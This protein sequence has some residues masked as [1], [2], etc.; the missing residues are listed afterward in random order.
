MAVSTPLHE[1]PSAPSAFDESA[2]REPVEALFREAKRRVR[3]RR[4]IVGAVMTGPWRV[5]T[6]FPDRNPLTLPQ[7]AGLYLIDADPAALTATPSTL[8][9]I[10][11]G[12][13]IAA[14]WSPDGDGIAAIDFSDSGRPLVAMRADGSES[15]VLVRLWPSDLFSGLAWHPG[16]DEQRMTGDGCRGIRHP[17]P[18]D[19]GDH[20]GR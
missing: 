15:R 18:T 4:L 14:T 1:S 8:E 7:P 20:D 12:H 13:F 17:A 3:R 16:L 10:A 9:P 11:S 5:T 2:V 6:P 19:R